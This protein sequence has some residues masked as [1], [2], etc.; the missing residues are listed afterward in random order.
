MS[1]PGRVAALEDATFERLAAAGPPGAVLRYGADPDQ[2]AENYGDTGAPTLVLVHGGFFR[3]TIDRAHA[4]PAAAAL[5]DAGW[6]VVLAEYRRVPASPHLAV[7]DLLGLDAALGSPA[8][9]WAG[10][11]AGGTL[12]LLR[13][14]APGRPPVPVLAL[15]AVSDLRR[16][17]AERLGDGA[18]VDWV[19]GTPEEQPGR[20]ATLDPAPRVATI[21]RALLVHGSDDA[22]VPVA[23]SVDLPA[24]HVVIDGAHHADLVDPSSARWPAVLAGLARLSR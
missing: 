12:A 11:S 16:A 5:A 10:H 24:A 20:Y 1:A 14:L 22:T 4:R 19:G 3:P 15:A 7:E 8:A 17:A 18:V 9:V 13:A 6:R 21:D 23:H 2:V